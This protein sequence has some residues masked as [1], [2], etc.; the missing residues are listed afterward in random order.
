MHTPNL[1]A[2]RLSAAQAGRQ[3]SDQPV[4]LPQHA[5]QDVWF[6]VLSTFT[7]PTWG[8]VGSLSAHGAANAGSLSAEWC[9]PACAC[10]EP[11]GSRC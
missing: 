7:T 11:S 5:L 10:V 9:A 1:A 2:W 8:R 6:L 3:P 4:I